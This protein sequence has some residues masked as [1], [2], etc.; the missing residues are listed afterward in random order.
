MTAAIQPLDPIAAA[1][2]DIAGSKSL[3]AAVADDLGQHERWLAHYRLAEKRHAR[4]VMLQ[5]LIWRLDLARQRLMRASRRAAL[6][7][8]RLARRTASLAARTAIFVYVTARDAVIAGIGWLRPRARTAASLLERWLAVCWLWCAARSRQLAALLARSSSTAWAWTRVHGAL[9]A[10]W[11]ARVSRAVAA[12]VLRWLMTTGRRARALARILWRRSRYGAGMAAA[13]TAA[14]ARA[15][16]IGLR[17]RSS[18]AA[19]WTTVNGRILG[20]ATLANAGRAA[21]WSGANARVAASLLRRNISDGAAWSAARTKQ[22]ARASIATSRQA[23]SWAALRLRDASHAASRAEATPV[24]AQAT[25]ALI[26]RRSTALI[27]FEPKRAGLPALRA[28]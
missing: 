14:T 8:L 24:G 7:M 4:L 3:M 6:L 9:A 1:E 19:H 2:A 25:R 28:S 13:W 21:S 15:A 17:R 12:A 23:Y 27:M 10:A 22:A 20:R 18:A 26:V 11:T 16:A 5:E